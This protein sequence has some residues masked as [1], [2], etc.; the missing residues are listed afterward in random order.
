MAVPP[1][2]PGAADGA[3]AKALLR[4]DLRARRE[5][6]VAANQPALRPTPELLALLQPGAVVA[7]YWPIGSEA[8]PRPLID[9][10][11]ARGS[12]IA[13]PRIERRD[14]PM[15]F[16]AWRP[17]DP[18]ERGQFGLSQP[19]ATAPECA[20]DVILTPLLGVDAALNRIGYG[21]GYYDR[22]FAAFPGARRIGIA[23]SAQQVPFVPVDPWDVPLH[24]LLT[25]Q[26][27]M[28]P[29]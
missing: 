15:R 10:A 25:E 27:W 2:D 29:K 3:K 12:T 18:L 24:A 7:A 28:L 22:A 20:P 1:P 23:W 6:F 13:L 9:A 5:A 19:V 4:A 21:A 8:D 11:I 17:G 16:L 26:G 14:Q